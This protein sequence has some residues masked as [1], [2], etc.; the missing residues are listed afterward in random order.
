MNAGMPLMR[1]LKPASCGI[2]NEFVNGHSETAS[3]L[4]I[5]GSLSSVIPS[6]FV[7]DSQAPCMNS[8]CRDMF[9]LRQMKCSPRSPI[10]FPPFFIALLTRRGSPYSTP[11]RR[12]R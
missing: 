10:S 3:R 4:P 9:A 2:L 1:R 8:N 12:M 6:N 5:M 11:R 7:L